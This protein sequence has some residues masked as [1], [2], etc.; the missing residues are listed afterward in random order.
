MMRVWLGAFVM[1]MPLVASA[2][3]AEPAPP[4]TDAPVTAEPVTATTPEPVVAEPVNKYPDGLRLMASDLTILRLN[5]TGLETRAR[6]GVQKKLYPSDKKI[7]ENNFFFAGVFPKLNP[8]SAHIALGGELQPASIFN[9]RSFVEVS[10][11]FGTFGYLQSFTS[12][13][14]NYSDATLADNK[15]NPTPATEPEAATG[16]RV[17]V[18][19]MLMMKFGKVALRALA[20]FDYWSFKTRNATA[21]EPTLDT[22]LPDNGW[23]V[24]T[25]TDLLYVTD[26]GLAAGLRH[27][28]VKPMYSTKHFADAADEAAYDGANAHQRLGLFAAYTLHDRGPSRFNKPTIILIVSWYLQHKYRAGEPSVLDPGHDA[29]DYRSR[30]F[31]YFVAGFAF[32]SDFLPVQ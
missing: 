17:S 22:L 20:M 26:K 29:D 12:A 9:V 2:E 18:Q 13:N 32:E 21:Y 31:P 3:E 19:P 4:V 16:M 25:D 14:A 15:D 10:K 11:Y 30:A 23:T 28:W 24:S 6:I 1:C 8:A 27:S 5:P 7:T